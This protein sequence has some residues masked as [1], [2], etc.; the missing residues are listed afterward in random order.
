MATTM[1]VS[2]DAVESSVRVLRNV[3]ESYARESGL[4][5]T[6]VY[7]LKVCVSEALANV[8][9][10]AYPKG[11]PGSVE[12]RV[13]EVGKELS[14]VVADHG[15]DHQRVHWED[16]GGFGLSFVYRLTDSCTFSAT[17]SG[18]TVEMLFPLSPRAGSGRRGRTGSL[19][20][21]TRG[22]TEPRVGL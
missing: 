13:R 14:V 7:A 17:S 20:H 19:F 5:E 1:Q 10:H 12:V 22:R 16:Q 11:E 15:R 8:V 21:F 9:K 18:T 2:A 6:Q 3:V 4:T